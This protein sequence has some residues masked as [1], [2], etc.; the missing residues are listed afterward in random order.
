M[1][2]ARPSRPFL[3]SSYYDLRDDF[4]TRSKRHRNFLLQLEYEL[5]HRRTPLSAELR[6][7][8]VKQIEQLNE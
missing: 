5:D 8:V 4:E 3:R 2:N 6:R 1:S 7:E